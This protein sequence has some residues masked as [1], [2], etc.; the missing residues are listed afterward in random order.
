MNRNE[1][2]KN[3]KLLFVILVVVLC[4]SGMLSI[5][6]Y[7]F[8]SS[9]RAEFNTP[10]DWTGSVILQGHYNH[11]HQY[12]PDP[13]SKKTYAYEYKR[14]LGQMVLQYGNT[15]MYRDEEDKPDISREE[16]DTKYYY[17][18]GFKIKEKVLSSAKD[19]ISEVGGTDYAVSDEM[20]YVTY[21][22]VENGV[23]H[24]FKFWNCSEKEISD[25]LG[26]VTYPSK[27]AIDAAEKDNKEQDDEKKGSN[28]FQF[29]I[30]AAI[31][32]MVVLWLI[33]KMRIPKEIKKQND[34]ENSEKHELQES[35]SH[36]NTVEEISED[37]YCHPLDFDN[38]LEDKCDSIPKESNNICKAFGMESPN[39]AYNHLVGENR[40]KIRDYGDRYNAHFLHCD[41]DGK[42]ILFW[43]KECEAFYLMQKSEFHGMGDDIYSSAFFNISGYEEADNWN[44]LF[45][46]DELLEK[47]PYKYLSVMDFSPSWTNE[48]KGIEEKSYSDVI[49]EISEMLSKCLDK[50]P[51]YLTEHDWHVYNKDGDAYSGRIDFYKLK[52]NVSLEDAVEMIVEMKQYCALKQSVKYTYEHELKKHIAFVLT[53]RALNCLTILSQNAKSI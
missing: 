6:V 51:L 52:D 30:I 27:T 12:V 9:L 15:D 35:L 29:F 46:G 25:V 50:D 40:V 44:N 48:K 10:E 21:V 36:Q 8:N 47:Y 11:K 26:S 31:I 49:H 45:N 37:E 22:H 53:M 4:I 7:A 28:L 38:T 43:C 5:T 17:E 23:V 14:G 39:A 20:A 2:I 16:F 24:R 33:K 19:Y 41:D 18:N 42:R 32:V 13:D 3:I 1:I 34:S